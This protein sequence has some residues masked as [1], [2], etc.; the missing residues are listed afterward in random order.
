MNFCAQFL[1]LNAS[2]KIY[3]RDL[4]YSK[5]I[6]EQMGIRYQSTYAKSKS[7]R[8]FWIELLFNQ[9][10]NGSFECSSKLKQLTLTSFWLSDVRK[11]TIEGSRGVEM[12]D[13]R[14]LMVFFKMEWLPMI[15]LLLCSRVELPASTLKI[16]VAVDRSDSI[17]NLL[18]LDS[19]RKCIVYSFP[20]ES[21]GYSN[22]S[23]FCTSCN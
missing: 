4:F 2:N 14:F 13:N 1:N 20:L 15:M 22:R 17:L 7:A 8:I 10:I 12:L 6:T 18:V 23:I 19:S 11:L 5:I 9:W 16:L 21:W 3:Y